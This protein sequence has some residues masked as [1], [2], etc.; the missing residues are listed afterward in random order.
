MLLSD[1]ATSILMDVATFVEVYV[2]VLLLPS[3]RLSGLMSRRQIDGCR[4]VG[5]D[6]ATSILTHK[7]AHCY[8]PLG[9]EVDGR[10]DAVEIDVLTS[11]LTEVAMSV[12]VLLR[13]EFSRLPAISMAHCLSQDVPHLFL[14]TVASIYSCQKTFTQSARQHIHLHFRRSSCEELVLYSTLG[15]LC[16]C[17]LR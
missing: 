10:R 4:D 16:I 12:A 9:I 3:Q 13:N 2:S 14:I 17:R 1:V 11:I 15:F 6:A 5:I 7:V 8:R